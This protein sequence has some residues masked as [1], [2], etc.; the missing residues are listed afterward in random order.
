MS[1][2]S[3]T[4]SVKESL[5]GSCAPF[6]LS[7][8]SSLEKLEFFR[9][10]NLKILSRNTQHTVELVILRHERSVYDKWC[11]KKKNG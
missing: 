9:N 4:M 10:S 5:E 1:G 2:N 11:E 7:G 6:K 3:D 8:T